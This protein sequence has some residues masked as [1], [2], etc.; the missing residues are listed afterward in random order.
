MRIFAVLAIIV[1]Y[2]EVTPLQFVMVSAALQKISKSFPTV[3]AN[4]NWTVIIVSLAG[5]AAMPLLGKM[6]DVWGKK[7]I[8][9]GAG[10][11]FVI[12]CLICAMTDDW[13]LFLIGRG[14]SA[15]A[16]PTQILAYGLV[17]DL[18]PRKYVPLGLGIT[19]AGVGFSG[20]LAPVIGGVLV[21]NFDW[22]AMFWFL[23][24]FALVMTPIVIFLVPETKVRVQ[25]RIDPLGVILLSGGVALILIYVDKGQDWGWGRATT[26]AWLIAGIVL[27]ALFFVVESRLRTPLIDLKILLNPRVGI[28]M[29]MALFGIVMLTYQSYAMGYMT[30]TPGAHD[31]QETVAQEV[32]AQAHQSAGINLPMSAVKIF[33]DPGYTYGNGFSLLQFAA[34]IS[35]FNTVVAMICGPLAAILARRIGARIPAIAS[36]AV[37]IGVGVAFALAPYDW[38]TYAA[39]SAVMGIGFG[40][41]YASAPILLVDAVPEDQQGITAGMFGIATALGSGI[42]LSVAAALLDNSPVRAHIDVMSRAVA[43]TIPQV[44]ADSGYTTCFWFATAAAVIGLAFALLLRHGR[45]PTTGGAVLAG[46]PASSVTTDGSADIPKSSSE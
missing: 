30:Q 12:G 40:F 5:G 9:V 20:I 21:D 18:L 11:F 29:L 38:G 43:Q 13:T 24:I 23:A 25:E 1:L 10:I 41:F 22:H 46:E 26:L 44:F 35:L 3:G 2:T 37:M 16:L 34:H 6:G 45:T 39:L 4:L 7:R 15:L 14:L 31:L 42:T 27:A 33:F 19:A 36:L 32:V 28:V 17:R 8:F